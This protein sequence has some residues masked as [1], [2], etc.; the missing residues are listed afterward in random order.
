MKIEF[1]DRFFEKYSYF[2][3]HENRSS[4]SRVVQCGRTDGRTEKDGGTDMTNL[5][6]PFRNFSNAPK[7]TIEISTRSHRS[8]ILHTLIQMYTFLCSY[9]SPRCPDK[10]PKHVAICFISKFKSCLSGMFISLVEN[11]ATG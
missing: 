2:K 10:K 8:I 3:Y 5:I 4:L 9:T 11:N 7:K 1:R 6:V